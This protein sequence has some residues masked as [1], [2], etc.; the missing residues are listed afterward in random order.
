[1]KQ[2]VP[3]IREIEEFLR[4]AAAPD[5]SFEHRPGQVLRVSVP[6]RLIYA[7][8]GLIQRVVS[9]WIERGWDWKEQRGANIRHEK[10]HAVTHPYREKGL[11]K[12][13]VKQ[14]REARFTTEELTSLV[15]YLEDY[16]IDFIIHKEDAEYQRIMRRDMGVAYG[17]YALMTRFVRRE[18]LRTVGLSP[19]H[20]VSFHLAGRV[21]SWDRVRR[22]FSEQRAFIR[23]YA[24]LMRRMKSE[25]DL[26]WAIPEAIEIR[27]KFWR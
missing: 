10:G 14:L 2:V 18:M 25:K 9:G 5:F 16:I 22:E 15:S 11:E 26:E 12:L 19:Y 1:V 23:E 21:I 6:R 13:D 7:D 27:K 20:A 24:D 4:E 3:S 17:G 8:L